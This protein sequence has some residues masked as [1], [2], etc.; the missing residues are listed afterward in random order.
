MT[1][2]LKTRVLT[3]TMKFPIRYYTKTSSNGSTYRYARH[4]ENY[5]G[6]KLVVSCPAPKG[7]SIKELTATLARMLDRRKSDVDLASVAIDPN[8]AVKQLADLFVKD[9]HDTK[10]PKTILERVRI[11]NGW[12]L[13]A[14]GP[15]K[16][17]NVRSSHIEPMLYKANSQS[18]ST[19]EHVWKVVKT[20]FNFAVENEY[21]ITK[22]PITEGLKKKV[23]GLLSAARDLAPTKDVTLAIEDVDAIFQETHGKPF[24]IV[25]HWQILCGMRIG[26]ALGVKWEDV[27][28]AKDVVNVRRQVSDASKSMFKNSRWADGAGPMVTSPKTK[29]GQREIPLQGQTKALLEATPEEERHGFIYQTGNGTP[30]EPGNYRERVFNPIR[31]AL[32]MKGVST[33]ELRRFF[34]SYLIAQLGVDII[35]VSKWMGHAKPETTMREYAKLIPEVEEQHKYRM[36]QAFGAV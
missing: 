9:A 33:H 6:Q 24:Q 3:I 17:G 28:F 31:D 25:F 27:D 18:A 14:L 30:C 32:D 4:I 5:E 8:M 23:R 10:K 19:L 2:Q 12:V 11:V 7:T 15:M 21:A 35:T 22:S 26:E 29:R 1:E 16:V 34:G 13:P 20:M 36:G